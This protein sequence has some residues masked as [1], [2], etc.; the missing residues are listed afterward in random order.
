[1]LKSLVFAIALLLGGC[2]P[3]KIADFT[4]K[5]PTLILERFFQGRAQGWGVMQSRF[6][7]FQ[8]QFRIEATGRWDEASRT[9]KLTEIY[10]FDDG[11][12]DTLEWHITKQDSGRYEGKEPRIDGTAQGEQAGNAFHWTYTRRV[13]AKD[14]SESSNG[15][16]DWFW[17][18]DENTLIARASVT[19]LGVEVATLSVFYRKM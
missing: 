12:I 17:L 2:T 4:G 5:Q 16:D 8:Q 13:P 7:A 10:T 18:Q 1:M 11:H 3:M 19:K 14:G 15:F 6:G 9:L